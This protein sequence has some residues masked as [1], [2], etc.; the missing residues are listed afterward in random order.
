ME[1]VTDW[2]MT[3][4][5]S[6]IR[7]DIVKKI[8]NIVLAFDAAINGTRVDPRNATNM[9]RRFLAASDDMPIDLGN[10]TDYVM[11]VAQL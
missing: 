4:A 8:V 9:T 5:N 7:K 3:K 1:N 6:T 11:K 10:L 2:M